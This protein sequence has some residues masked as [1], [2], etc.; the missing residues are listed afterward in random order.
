MHHDE[1]VYA[2]RIAQQG[3]PWFDMHGLK[4]T[5]EITNCAEDLDRHYRILANPILDIKL[6]KRLL[7]QPDK[8]SH[9]L[10]V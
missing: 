6:F 3:T 10:H 7:Q 5:F 4:P 8:R 9:S 1:A 2:I